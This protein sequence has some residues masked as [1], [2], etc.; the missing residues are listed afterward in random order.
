MAE[1]IGKYTVETFAQAN[2]LC[3][4]SALNKLSKLK[5]KGL[6]KVSGGGKQK[7]IYTIYKRPAIATNGF[8][9][10]VNKFSPVK[11]VPKFKH[12]VKGRY[13]VEHAIVDGIKIGDS[14][15]LDAT[16]YLFNHI[17]NWKR[18]MDIAKEKNIYNKVI[19][20][21]KEARKRIKTKKMPERYLK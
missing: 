6:V 21:Y 12:Q 20:M 3:R 5:K 13:T 8:Y 16:L 18:L 15:T 7:R 14:R 19:V 9:D 1:I 11:L 4:Q 2:N 10:V 17:K